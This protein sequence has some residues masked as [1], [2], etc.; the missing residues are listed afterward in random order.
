MMRLKV[1]QV[2][3]AHHTLNAIVS[4]NRPMPQ[5]GA[6]RLARLKMKID[7][8][9]VPIIEK[10]DALLIRLAAPVE[11]S[12]GNF[13]VTPEFAAAWKELA[14]DEIEVTVEPIPLA[15]LDLGDAVAGAITAAELCVLGE[16][17]TE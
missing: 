14:D 4:E 3:D 12:P 11:E 17:V 2:F 7:A 16:L 1:Q 10:R 9:A 6:Y 15:M 5:K 13:T 8:E